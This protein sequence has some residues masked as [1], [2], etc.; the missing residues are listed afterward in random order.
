[1]SVF[2]AAESTGG[3]GGMMQSDSVVMRRAGG[4]AGR[5]WYDSGPNFMTSLSPDLVVAT[6][7]SNFIHFLI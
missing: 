7:H 6:T 4:T 3:R 1:M 5:G 2:A